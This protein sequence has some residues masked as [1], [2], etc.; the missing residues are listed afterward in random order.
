[1]KE[2]EAGFNRQRFGGQTTGFRVWH[3][4]WRVYPVGEYT[5]D[6]DFAH[7]YGPQWGFLQ[8]RE[9]DSVGAGRRLADQDL[10]EQDKKVARHAD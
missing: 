7:L 3:P 1:M 5:M 6:I 2:Q 8:S 9:P 4:A 10:S